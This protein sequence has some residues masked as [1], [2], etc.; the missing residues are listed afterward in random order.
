MG[1]R[2]TLK[3]LQQNRMK[4]KIYFQD[5]ELSTKKQKFSS[6]YKTFKQNHNIISRSINKVLH[7]KVTFFI[8]KQKPTN[9]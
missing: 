3:N 7:N 4:T 1:T 8:T 9:V 6:N 2:L 5:F